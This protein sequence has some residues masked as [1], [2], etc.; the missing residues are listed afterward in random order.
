M[1]ST[2]EISIPPQVQPPSQSF[3]PESFEEAIAVC[4]AVH[5]VDPRLNLLPPDEAVKLSPTLG[6]ATKIVDQYAALVDGLPHPAASHDNR[7]D[8]RV[9]SSFNTHY[10]EDTLALQLARACGLQGG[11]YERRK[12]VEADHEAQVTAYLNAELLPVTLT[13]EQGDEAVRA[14]RWHAVSAEYEGERMIA[15]KVL[16][17]HGLELI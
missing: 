1:Y 6:V 9:V 3:A 15:R 16:Q 7:I 2:L 10:P 13:P 8:R 12:A 17:S 11:R 4:K 14:L 5:E